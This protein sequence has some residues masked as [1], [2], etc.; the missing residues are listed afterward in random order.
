MKAKGR[1]IPVKAL[2]VVKIPAGHT[3]TGTAGMKIF[4]AGIASALIVDVPV[5]HVTNIISPIMRPN[6][7]LMVASTVSVWAMLGIAG[8]AVCPAAVAPLAYI[9]GET[10]APGWTTIC[11]PDPSQL[12]IATLRSVQRSAITIMA[13]TAHTFLNPAE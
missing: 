13:T 3:A 6:S 5:V 12:P 1:T 9:V 7:A 11:A 10:T 4:G 8:P 2:T